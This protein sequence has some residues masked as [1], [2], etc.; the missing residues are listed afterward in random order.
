M[1][2]ARARAAAVAVRR[3]CWHQHCTRRTILA[4]PGSVSATPRIKDVADEAPA[5]APAPTEAVAKET[6][7][8]ETFNIDP[9][10]PW[11]GLPDFISFTNRVKATAIDVSLCTAVSAP[12]AEAT[13]AMGTTLKPAIFVGTALFMLR[14]VLPITGGRR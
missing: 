5:A 10:D 9:S 12:V 3:P 4:A 2:V 13:L 14:D 6:E 7:M 8:T 11:K 1:L